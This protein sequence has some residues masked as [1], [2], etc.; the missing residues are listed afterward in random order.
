M[1]VIADVTAA[2]PGGSAATTAAEPPRTGAVLGDAALGAAESGAEAVLGA[3]GGAVI[4]GGVA[5]VTSRDVSAD[6]AD[7][8]AASSG[9]GGVCCSI[10]CSICVGAGGA[11][12]DAGA[13]VGF[14]GVAVSTSFFGG[15]GLMTGRGGVISSRAG[16]AGGSLTISSATKR[17][18][19]GG[20]VEA[21]IRLSAP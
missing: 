2:E 16:G 4:I 17:P 13:G 11:G 20:G 18:V 12:V 19:R 8:G 10:G 9:G 3:E 6:S 7:R 15:F 1:R 14:G 21:G 5:V